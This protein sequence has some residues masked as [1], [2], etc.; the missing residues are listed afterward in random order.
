MGEK[1]LYLIPTKVNDF[2]YSFENDPGKL[3]KDFFTEI[4]VDI[5]ENNIY[6]SEIEGARV[7]RKT[8]YDRLILEIWTDGT[9]NPEEALKQASVIMA[10]HF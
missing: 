1:P 6:D 7:G 9:I 5:N 4:I 3:K 8:N 2:L 10:N